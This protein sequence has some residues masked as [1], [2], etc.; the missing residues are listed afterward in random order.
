MSRKRILFVAENVTL[1][2]VV[3]L[4]AL[5]RELPTERYEVHFACGSFSPV[6]FAGT[7]FARW[8]IPTIDG[9]DSLRRL[10]RGQ[11]IY[12]TRLLARYVA[13]ELDLIER[14]RPDLV[15][16][17]FRLSL[18]ISA[19]LSGVRLATLIN[20]YWSPF[21][22]REA[23]PVPDHPMVK[24]LGVALAERYFPQALP[25]VFAHFAA[26]VNALR[27]RHGL[28][29]VGSLLEVLTHGDYTLYP[30]VPEL[31]PTS[32]LPSSHRYL[33]AI[34][35]SPDVPVPDCLNEHGTEPLVYVTLGSS[36][37]IE[38]LDAV[39]EALSG[40]PVIGLLA[41]AG[42]VRAAHLPANVR[43]VD[44][45]P[46]V[47]AAGAA[48]FVVT[49][50]GSSTGYQALRQGRPVLGIASNLDQYLA[51]S[52][53]RRAGAGVLVRAGSATVQELSSAM[54]TL[55]ES[56][57]LESGATAVAQAFARVDCHARFAQFL[58]DVL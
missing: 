16:G 25:K 56:S 42:R 3:R 13:A 57:E 29:P 10:E 44:F 51:M 49:N 12:E 32:G 38:V 45:V 18:A 43:A 17:D 31:C 40:L 26:P 37:K 15:I 5:A 8:T 21:A 6:A 4:V 11:R 27:K 30:D 52:A 19:P 2:Q 22:E 58:N 20:A 28:A 47:L 39:L 33:G 7:S 46:G 14:V 48:R 9:Q 50:G 41:T 53:I 24:L 55:L 54:Q 36:G 34:E 23:F 1:A 35:W